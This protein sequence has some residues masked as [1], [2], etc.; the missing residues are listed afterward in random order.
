MLQ[1]ISRT[2]SNTEMEQIF[3]PL[4]NEQYAFYKTIHTERSMYTILKVTNTSAESSP[5]VFHEFHMTH[6]LFF[7]TSA[8]TISAAII[9]CCSSARYTYQHGHD[10][11]ECGILYY[12]ALFVVSA[13]RLIFVPF[14]TSL[15]FRP[16][17]HLTFHQ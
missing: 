2:K 5:Q 15:S 9:L 12:S 17:F 6:P 3:K 13:V 11:P 1:N 7:Y 16:P 10:I 14:T 4:E 8:I